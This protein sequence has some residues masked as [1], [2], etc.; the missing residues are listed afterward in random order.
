MAPP[1]WLTFL[2][3]LMVL[4][5]GGYR[6]AVSLRSKEAQKRAEKRVGGLYSLPRRRHMLFGAVY[7]IMG[8]FLILAAF[9]IDVTGLK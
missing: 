7:V 4:A 9:G 2:C 8:V 5:F 1:P 3:G 6:L